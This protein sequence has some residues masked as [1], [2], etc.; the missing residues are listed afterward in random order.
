MKNQI[1]TMAAIA[2]LFIASSMANAQER[3][4]ENHG[5]YDWKDRFKAEKIAYLTDAIELT[6]A[7]AEKF[8]PIYNRCEAEKEQCFM[9]S[10]TA[11]K[12]LDDAIKTGKDDKE[13]AA[14]LDKYLSCQ[15][16][17]MDIDKKYLPEYS[18][19]L[20][21]KKVAKLFIGEESFRR[22]QINRLKRDDPKGGR[23]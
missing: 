1:L 2:M 23:H 8:W 13:I 11:Y 20:S 4:K 22:H 17:G 9:E 19:I 16:N 18:K 14:L 3:D 6:S 12:A 7:E 5:S 21:S 15:N 10:M